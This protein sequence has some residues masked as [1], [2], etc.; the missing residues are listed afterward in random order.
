M[1][2]RIEICADM[3][4]RL[5][6]HNYDTMRCKEE[7]V[8]IVSR[9]KEVYKLIDSL[10]IDS[11]TYTNEYN[12]LHAEVKELSRQRIELKNRIARNKRYGKNIIDIN[13]LV[14]KN[15]VDNFNKLLD[16]DTY[17]LRGIK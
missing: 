6:D 7:L 14:S 13:S 12:L 17:I 4:K 11:T 8:P 9:L 2:T 5:T 10:D 3:S 15:I 16:K 1:M